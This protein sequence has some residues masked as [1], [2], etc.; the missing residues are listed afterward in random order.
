MSGKP[1]A[2][3]SVTAPCRNC[4][5][6]TRIRGRCRAGRST[7]SATC[8]GNHRRE[9][10]RGLRQQEAALFGMP[11]AIVLHDLD[12]AHCC[13]LARG[14]LRR[15]G[16]S[17]QRRHDCPLVTT[18]LMLDSAGFPRAC[19]ILPGN[20]SECGA[21]ADAIARLR[22]E[23]APEQPQPTV[24]MD[25]GIATEA[26][27]AWLREQGLDWIYVKRGRQPPPPEGA[28]D[29]DVITASE[30]T[31]QAW[32]LGRYLK[33]RSHLPEALSLSQPR[34]RA[35]AQ[36]QRNR[37]SHPSSLRCRRH[38]RESARHGQGN[39]LSIHN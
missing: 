16:R 20:L 14:A 19:E 15:R 34:H 29:L 13:G 22:Q 32:C 21:L 28:P 37:T 31:L 11:D 10:Q 38:D 6:T 18:A 5:A 35:I 2:G 33:R 4:S 23:C 25:A 7:A 30:T 3:C 1:A 8:C 39:P 12:N 36:I 24:V 9:L 17:K 26:N 27:L